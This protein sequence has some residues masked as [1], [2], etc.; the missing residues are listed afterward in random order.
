MRKRKTPLRK[1]I[2]CYERKAKQELLRVVRSKEGH[3]DIDRVG[4]MNGRGAYICPTH[5]CLDRIEKNQQLSRALK[6]DIPD[7]LYDKIRDIIEDD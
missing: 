6:A 4:K 5:N 7:E 1:C 2:A 3:I